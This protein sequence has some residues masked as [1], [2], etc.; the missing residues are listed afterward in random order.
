MTQILNI[1]RLK[2]CFKLIH[3]LLQFGAPCQN[4]YENDYNN[5]TIY[6]TKYIYIYLKT[7]NIY[8]FSNDDTKI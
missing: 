3:S 6:K 2:Y 4:S 5:M 1:A 7:Y 8:V